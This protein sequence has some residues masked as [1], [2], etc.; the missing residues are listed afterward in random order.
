MSWSPSTAALPF[1]MTRT[2]KFPCGSAYEI[3]SSDSKVLRA[4]LYFTSAVCAVSDVIHEP[5]SATGRLPSL[6]GL[7][8]E[9]ALTVLVDGSMVDAAGPGSGPPRTVL[10]CA[11]WRP[12]SPKPQ[13]V[14]R[15][16]SVAA[17]MA[18]HDVR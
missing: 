6:V 1:W 9:G 8:L 15:S 3:T 14:D 10:C 5:T 2:S 7:G 13:A 11:P 12:P 17:A 4:K 18:V 16:A